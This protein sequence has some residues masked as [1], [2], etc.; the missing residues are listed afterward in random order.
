M[1]ENTKTYVPDV[2]AA[3]SIDEQIKAATLQAAQLELQL[4]KE[5]LEAK[6]L[7][8]E[9]RKASIGELREKQ[10]ERAL[11]LAQAKRELQDKSRVF[12]QDR[13]V[14]ELRQ[15]KCNHQKGGL[16]NQ[17]DL[18]PLHTGGDSPK[19]SIIRHRM[20]DGSMWI[21][22]T[23]CR[24]S[25]MPPV[26]INFYFDAQGRKVAPKDGVFDNTKYLAAKQEYIE[27]QKMTTSGSPS[28]SVICQFFKWELDKDGVGQWVDGTEA[29]R[30]S[31]ANTNLR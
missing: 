7:E 4:K 24:K 11:A 2:L 16:I 9:E 19:K 1:A 26:K 25:W 22:C 13:L 23:R 5:E 27:A 31:V 17:R 21:R 3:G 20:I 15:S 6:R 18:T 12:N 28:S 30:E 14:D 8:I 10:S 29:Y